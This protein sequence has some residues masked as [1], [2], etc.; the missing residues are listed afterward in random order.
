MS[1]SIL[2]LT[3]TLSP[4]D[5][6]AAQE[7]MADA[8]SS[9]TPVYPLGAG[10]MLGRGANCDRQGGPLPSGLGL[11]TE[12]LNKVIDHAEGDLT[13]TVESG[14]TIAK[15]AKLLAAK[16]QRL[17]V[18]IPNPAQATVG[19]AVALGGGGP[20]RFSRGTMRDYVIGFS[21]VDGTGKAFAGGGRVVKNAA[22]YDMCRLMTGSMG[23]LV[24]ITQVTLMVKPLPD[25]SAFLSCDL[26]DFDTTEQILTDLVRS[27]TLPAAVELLAGPAWQEDS[28]LGSID[29]NSARLLVGFEGAKADVEWMLD[30]LGNHWQNVIGQAPTIVKKSQASNLWSRLTEFPDQ[31]DTK[32]EN[33]PLLVQITT[34]PSKLVDLI[35]QVQK[36]DP[37]VSIQAHAGDGILRA[38]FQIEPD[39]VADFVKEKLRPTVDTAD[40]RMVVLDY[41]ERAKLDQ[42]AVWGT[43]SDGI[44]VMR[45]IKDRFDPQGLLNPG[46]F[47]F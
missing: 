33:R 6:A 42:K 15:L 7:A 12:K 30:T 19:G 32:E 8:V 29:G 38:C 41:P 45:A 10:T 24:L 25:E 20:R 3:E 27:E 17:P 31:S 18:D 4:A 1:N 21:A 46:R 22:G 36:I 2:P 11:S 13:I 9:G 16:N 39:G 43:P 23:T 40:A 47:I 44:D 35:C 28:A 34:L 14:V 26:S 37:E 5:Q